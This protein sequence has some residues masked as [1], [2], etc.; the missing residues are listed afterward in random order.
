MGY[1]EVEN[2]NYLSIL[3]RIYIKQDSR[4]FI[5]SIDSIKLLLIC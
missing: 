1:D 4:N 3:N 5:D 2:S